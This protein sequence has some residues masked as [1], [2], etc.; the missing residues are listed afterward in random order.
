MSFCF[1]K[2]ARLLK[3]FQFRRMTN[4]SKSHVGRLIIVEVR[5]NQTPST[6]LGVTVSRRYG[7]SHE[8]NR[9]KRIVR[10]AFR[11]NRKNLIQ[12][13]DLNIRPRSL[14][15]DASSLDISQELCHLVGDL[16]SIQVKNKL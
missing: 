10:D 8:R 7:K 4:Q 14:A 5:A 12:G 13:F 6:R 16:C 11:L 2:S 1:P 15:K 3:R 9:F